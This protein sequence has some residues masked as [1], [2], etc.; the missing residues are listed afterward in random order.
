MFLH[1]IGAFRRSQARKEGAANRGK[2]QWPRDRR[3]IEKKKIFTHIASENIPKS[4]GIPI[5]SEILP[6]YRNHWMGWGLNMLIDIIRLMPIGP[7]MSV[8]VLIA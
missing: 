4:N 1:L 3:G 6:S 7:P 2:E 5:R 8:A